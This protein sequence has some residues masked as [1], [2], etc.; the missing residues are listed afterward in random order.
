MSRASQVAALA[1]LAGCATA[2]T[3]LP[4]APPPAPTPAAL[5]LARADSLLERGDYQQAQ[6]AYGDFARQ[7]SDD[8]AA[9]RAVATRDLLASLATA[10]R[11]ALRLNAEALRLRE[12]TADAERDLGRL[13]RDLGAREGELAR[14]RQELAERQAE[15]GRLV[16]ETEQLRGDLEKLKSVD[17]RLER[18]R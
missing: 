13:R 18:R 7:Y 1:L 8:S 3:A 10:N 16:A 15:L 6:E 12:Q 17:L 14:M 2:P 11:E 4:P 5:L 9:P